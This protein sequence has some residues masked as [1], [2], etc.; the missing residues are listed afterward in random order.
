LRAKYPEAFARECHVSA[1]PCVA[2]VME[3]GGG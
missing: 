1:G 2:G 3:G